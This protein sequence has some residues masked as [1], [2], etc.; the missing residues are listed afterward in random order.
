MITS[1]F[2]VVIMKRKSGFFARLNAT[3]PVTVKRVQRLEQLA[4]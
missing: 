4:A 1:F 3:H 2:S